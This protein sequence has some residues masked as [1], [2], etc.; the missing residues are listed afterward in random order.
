LLGCAGDTDRHR[1]PVRDARREGDAG[2]CPM[3]GTGG[4]NG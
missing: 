3:T 4:T 2:T 1:D